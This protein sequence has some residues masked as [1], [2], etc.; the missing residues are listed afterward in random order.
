MDEILLVPVLLQKT[1]EVA[2]IRDSRGKLGGE[3][4]KARGTCCGGAWRV[5]APATGEFF[6]EDEVSWGGTAALAVSCALRCSWR[7]KNIDEQRERETQGRD[8]KDRGRETKGRPGPMLVAA[9]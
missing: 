1:K 2:E 7:G 6:P 9:G 8:G 4:E 5:E 3:E